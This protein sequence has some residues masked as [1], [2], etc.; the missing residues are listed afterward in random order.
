MTAL[1]SQGPVESNPLIFMSV[2]LWPDTSKATDI[3]LFKA[4]PFAYFSFS[5]RPPPNVRLGTRQAYEVT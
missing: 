3:E 2:P 4:D 5:L 1:G